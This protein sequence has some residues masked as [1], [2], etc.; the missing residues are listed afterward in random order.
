VAQLEPVGGR[1]VSRR[2]VS[3]IIALV[4]PRHVVWDW[5]GTL[6][7]DLRVVIESLNVGTARFGIPALDED[8]YRDHFTRPVRSF[9]DSLFGRPVTDMEWL[10]LNK[11]FHDEYYARSYRAPLTVDAVE[12][13]DRVAALG[14]SQS[15]LSMSVHDHLLAAVSSRGLADRFTLIDGLT[16]ATGG[17]KS[18]HLKSHLAELDRDPADVIVIGDTPDDATAARQV[19]A[20]VVLY[21]GGSHHLPTLEAM[22]VAVAHTLYDAVELAM[23]IHQ[24]D[25][26]E[27]LV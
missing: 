26:A 16:E 3:A 6:L 7:D 11:T 5:N 9:Y 21:D 13:V 27:S 15:L 14:W 19:G 25:D 24:G 23:R 18:E 10:H 22:G 12:A 17:L 4:P 1:G 2:G 8:G 20:A